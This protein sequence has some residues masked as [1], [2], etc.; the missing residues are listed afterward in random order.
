MRYISYLIISTI[1]FIFQTTLCN[2]IAI[3]GVKPNFMLIFI[4]TAA[5][6][7]GNSDGLL[8]GIIMG[9]LQDCYF[10]HVIGSN[11]FLYGIM[12]Y[13]A[14]CLTEH[15][16]KENIVAPMFLILIATLAYNFGFYLLNIILKGYTTLNIYIILNI[17][18]EI[19]YNIIFGFAVYFIVYTLQNSS[20][21]KIGHKHRF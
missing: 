12:G 20:W 15:F 2:Y 5:F 18:P 8:I 14:G 11:L 3:A 16:N 7:K 19:I 4:V 17:L 1:I 9:L 10:G 13:I 21:D 6:F